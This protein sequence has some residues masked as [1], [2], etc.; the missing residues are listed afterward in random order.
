[1]EKPQMYITKWKDP[2]PKDCILWDSN[3]MTWKKGQ[4]GEGSTKGSGFQGTERDE[5]EEH[6]RF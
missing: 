6:Q 1:M 2:T 4:N 5:K 3:Y